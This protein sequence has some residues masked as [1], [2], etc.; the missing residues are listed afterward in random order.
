MPGIAG[1]PWQPLL[2]QDTP[3]VSQ[4]CSPSRTLSLKTQ[5]EEKTGSDSIR[6]S[7]SQFL[8]PRLK[9]TEIRTEIC[10]KGV[11]AAKCHQLLAFCCNCFYPRAFKK[12][13]SSSRIL[14]TATGVLLWELG[15][16]NSCSIQHTAGLFGSG[17][18]E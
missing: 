15:V 9:L 6:Q 3:P 7:G 1:E 17:N 4:V 8:A 14:F 2:C 10:S 13:P 5:G 16:S 18:E 12:L 11:N